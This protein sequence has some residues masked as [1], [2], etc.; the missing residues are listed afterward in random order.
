MRAI[1]TIIALCTAV[2]A[3]GQIY[4]DSYRFK[5]GAQL[6][7]DEY[8]GA[9]AAYSLRKL[10]TNFLGNAIT[11]RRSSN[12][13]TLGIGFLN[14]YL[15][16]VALKN[17]CGTTSSDTCSVRIFFDQSGNGINAIQDTIFNQPAIL[18]GGNINYYQGDVAIKFNGTSS[19]LRITRQN[20]IAQ[21]YTI[22]AVANTNVNT[23]NTGSRQY[24]MDGLG[25]TGA[26]NRLIYTLRGNQTNFPSIWA[27]STFVAHNVA[28][29]TNQVLFYGLYNT[30]SSQVSQNNLSAVTGSAGNN[31]LGSFVIGTNFSVNADWLDGSIKEFVLYNSNQSSSR[32]GISTNINNF[33]SIY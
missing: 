1:I 23:G 33:Y 10:N 21:P 17:F 26:A 29:S 19:Y 9:A 8:G 24:I 11:V 28:T 32:T 2:A 4:I 3:S 15:D 13:D 6:L 22:F 27:G 20:I 14:N 16:T 30:S 7:L 5:G 31:A 18:I 25:G 12:N